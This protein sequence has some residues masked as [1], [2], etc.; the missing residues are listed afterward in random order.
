LFLTE[1]ETVDFFCF[2]EDQILSVSRLK[3][4]VAFGLIFVAD[5]TTWPSG[6]VSILNYFQ[7]SIMFQS[8]LSEGLNSS[9]R[10]GS[11]TVVSG[12]VHLGLVGLVAWLSARPAEVPV[13]VPELVFVKARAPALAA[14]STAMAN[15]PAAAQRE[16]RPKKRSELVQPKKLTPDGPAEQKQD[17]PAAYGPHGSDEQTA[18][19][20]SASGSPTGSG[21]DTGLGSGDLGSVGS[22]VVAFGAG[23]TLPGYDKA[24]LMSDV[25]TTEARLAKVQGSMIVR[26]SILPNGTVRNCTVLKGLPYLSDEVVEKLEALVVSPVTF[27][28]APVGVKYTFNFSFVLR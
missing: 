9:S 3:G 14:L 5:G 15:A 11:G 27:Q 24:A 13:K 18:G 22:D 17:E 2:G 16:A 10:L 4:I 23:M 1:N 19:I 25:Y 28:G 8:A 21:P 26:C 20:G 7:G 6:G 12:A